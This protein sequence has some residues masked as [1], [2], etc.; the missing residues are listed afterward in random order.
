MN[1]NEPISEQHSPRQTIYTIGYAGFSVP[2]FIE[3]LH[4]NNIN[5]VVDVRSSPHSAYY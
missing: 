3:T 2:E 1:T 5:V 4:A